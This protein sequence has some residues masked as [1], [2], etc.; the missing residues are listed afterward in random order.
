MVFECFFMHRC[1]TV[2]IALEATLAY[3]QVV[4]GDAL[5]A[6]HAS[7]CFTPGSTDIAGKHGCLAHSFPSA[8]LK[9]YQNQRL[10]GDVIPASDAE[11]F[12]R[13]ASRVKGTL[14]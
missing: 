8:V 3:G 12:T 10:D 4:T 11:T 14:S 6:V 1:P 9:K 2:V 7:A 13:S 5:V